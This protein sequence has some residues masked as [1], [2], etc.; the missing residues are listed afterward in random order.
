MSQTLDDIFL[1]PLGQRVRWQD[2]RHQEDFVIV[3]RRYEEGASSIV[4]QYALLPA[5]MV[6]DVGRVRSGIWADERE[7]TPVE[8]TRASC[9]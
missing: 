8:D 9:P 5:T 6:G 7:V 4:V 1:Y 2:M 3:R